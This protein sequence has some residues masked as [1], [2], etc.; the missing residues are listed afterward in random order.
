MN[1]LGSVAQ[2]NG[3]S[4]ASIRLPMNGD[5]SMFSGGSGQKLR[6][7]TIKNRAALNTSEG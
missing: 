2:P 5:V 1:N 4:N 3:I 7:M 6:G